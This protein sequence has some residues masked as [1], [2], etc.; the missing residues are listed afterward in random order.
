MFLNTNENYDSVGPFYPKWG[1]KKEIMTSFV[2]YV[3]P[4]QTL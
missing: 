4:K 1:S 2:R 3:T